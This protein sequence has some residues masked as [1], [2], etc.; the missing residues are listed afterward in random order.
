MPNIKPDAKYGLSTAKPIENFSE[1]YGYLKFQHRHLS[2][3]QKGYT[4]QNFRLSTNLNCYRNSN[5]NTNLLILQS[6]YSIAT[7]FYDWNIYFLQRV[8]TTETFCI[9][10]TLE[11]YLKF[12]KVV[13]LG[14]VYINNTALGSKCGMIFLGVLQINLKKKTNEFISRVIC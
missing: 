2:N 14:S 3:F 1:T 6:F 12:R 10:K 8:S 4:V 13:S 5:S 9:G 11:V 7:S